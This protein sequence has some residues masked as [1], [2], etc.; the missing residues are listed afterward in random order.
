MLNEL[1][2]RGLK[3]VVSVAVKEAGGQENCTAISSRIRR[4]AAFSDYANVEHPA[5]HIPLDVAIEIDRF[6]RNGRLVR[7][8]ARLLG[9]LLIPMPR[10]RMDGSKVEVLAA[11]IKET[12]EAVAAIAPYLDEASNRLPSPSHRCHT[13]RQIDEAIEALLAARARL[14]PPKSDD[15]GG[16]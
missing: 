15:E 9:Y 13:I 4:A 10:P 5:R 6:N 1:E 12:G 16:E 11:T 14:D 7:A 3:A 2:R 8:G